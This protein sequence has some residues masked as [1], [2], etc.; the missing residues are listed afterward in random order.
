MNE[1]D[2]LVFDIG[3]TYT[4]GI[5]YGK[6]GFLARSQSPTTIDNIEIGLQKV[7]EKITDKLGKEKI[8]AKEILSTSSAAG[9]LRMVA[10]GY[11]PRVTAK[12]AKEVAMASGAKI[13][14]II[15][16]EENDEFK[17]EILKETA[18]DIVLLAGGTDGGN[19]KSLE[20]NARLI[21]DS[22]IDATIILAGNIKAQPEIEK[23]LVD[24]EGYKVKRV[25]NVM[26]TIHQLNTD[27]ARKAIHE[28]FIR[29]ITHAQGLSGI[30][31][32]IT[33][34]T[35]IPTPGSVLLAAELL[36]KGTHE[37]D[38][39]GNLILIDMGGA[40]TDIHSIIPDLDEMDD[41]EKGLI[42]NDEKQAT[43]RTVEG[44][45]GLRVSARGIVDTVGKKAILNRIENNDVEDFERY[46]GKISEN[47]EYIAQ[48]EKEKKY[49]IALAISAI[50]VALKR[51]A[52]YKA[53]EYKPEK[54]IVPGTPIG[55]D[56]R[57]VDT[58]I[59][60]GG[61]FAHLPKGI[62]DMIVN[63]AFANKGISL[64]PEEFEIYCDSYYS[65][66]SIGALSEKYPEKSLT[67]GLKQINY[68]K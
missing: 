50:E 2:I 42:V 43:F 25:P 52:G 48:N 1:V 38:G 55:R 45:L 23:M 49:D 9:G 46:I 41:E 26:P 21:V 17:K 39:V 6:N 7:R 19:D 10:I 51:H 30:L 18:P 54:G 63:K 53:E 47:P 3:S 44:N 12:A 24:K 62:V 20:K 64:L 59:C 68:T 56:L 57:E 29:Q 66:F 14:E 8:E 11:M 32:I 5:A 40:T 31:N 37:K 67:W 4:K 34:E 61:I 22:G 13:L 36:A 58:I 27:P 28:E 15:S 65:L 60:A 35:V 16:D 33:N